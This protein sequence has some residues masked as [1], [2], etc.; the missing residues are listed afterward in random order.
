M[1]LGPDGFDKIA[2]IGSAPSSIGLAPFD[3]PTWAIWCCSPA[4]FAYV[5]PKRSDVWFELHRWQ[6]SEPGKSGAPGTKPYFSPEF[7][8]FLAQHKGPVFMSEIQP[9]IPPSVLYPYADM[10]EKFGPYHFTSTIA[11]MLALAIEQGPK[12]IGMFG[13]DMAAQSEWA[14]QRPGC[15]HF[16]G[17]AAALG[18]N[19][20]LPPESDLMRHSTLYG[21]GEH[22]PRHVKLLARLTEFEQRKAM[23]QNQLQTCNLEMHF[24]N[25]AIDATKYDLEVWSDDIRPNPL[26]AVSFSGSYLK[27]PA[28]EPASTGAAVTDLKAA[29]G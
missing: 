10:L 1:K 23:V 4:V 3:D 29:T 8:L 9:T 19:I 14:Y 11:W 28:G 20:V 17:M 24:L 16:L 5:A 7:A 15:Q 25:G 27:T 26:Q 2:I 13:V 21:I 6:P 22:N 18:I 12:T